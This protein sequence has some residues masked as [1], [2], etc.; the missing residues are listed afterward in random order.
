MGGRRG[1]DLGSLVGTGG[2]VAGGKREVTRAI[3]TED[4]REI[5]LASAKLIAKSD[6]GLEGLRLG[7]K[8]APYISEHYKRLSSLSRGEREEE[9][10]RAWSQIK[11]R[12]S[13]QTS[14][15]VD[16][17]VVVSARE[18]FALEGEGDR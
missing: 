17:A 1:G 16:N 6:L 9:V 12:E 5:A 11:Q 2:A 10:R 14:K 4:P 13:I 8:L 3:R 18:A 7:L 15:E